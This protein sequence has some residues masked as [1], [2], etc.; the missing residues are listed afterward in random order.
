MLF[1]QG[2][3][4]FVFNRTHSKAD[5]MLEKGAKWAS[6]PADIARQCSVTFSCVFSDDALKEVFESWLSGK[7]QKGSIFVDCSTVYPDTIRGLDAEAQK[8]GQHML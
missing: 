1:K 3:T 7:P 5:P 2:S 8:A 4:L 6:S